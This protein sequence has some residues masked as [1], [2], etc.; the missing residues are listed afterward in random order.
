[1]QYFF[2]FKFF[3]SSFSVPFLRRSYSS[4]SSFPS[5]ASFSSNPTSH[6]DFP[7]LFGFCMYFSRCLN[8]CCCRSSVLFILF[9]SSQIA[10]RNGNC[11]SLCSGCCVIVSIDSATVFATTKKMW[12]SV[13]WILFLLVFLLLFFFSCYR[14]S[15]LYFL[16]IPFTL[17]IIRFCVLWRSFPARDSAYCCC[18]VSV[19]WPEIETRNVFST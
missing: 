14:R 13:V 19:C 12:L 3:A 15:S 6:R 10:T 18:L 11:F 16:H 9:T 7:Q 4:S 17:E 1:M 2:I 5:S 8:H